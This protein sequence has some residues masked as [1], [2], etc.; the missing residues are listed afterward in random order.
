VT[1][2]DR[3][4]DAIIVGESERAFTS[5]Q[6]LHLAP[7]FLAHGVRVWLPELDGPVDLIDPVKGATSRLWLRSAATRVWGHR[8]HGGADVGLL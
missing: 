7:I 1:S 2:P 4:F 3:E 6:L 8:S 5:T